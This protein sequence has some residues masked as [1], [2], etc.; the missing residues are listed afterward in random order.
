MTGL[1]R[2][3]RRFEVY[4]EP[5][6]GWYRA[7][8]WIV[9]GEE[10]VTSIVKAFSR[11]RPRHEIGMFGSAINFVYFQLSAGFV[12][13]GLVT[14]Q[15]FK[16]L[17]GGRFIAIGFVQKS[18]HLIERSVFE[19]ELDDV[20]YRGQLIRHGCV[21]PFLES[22]GYSCSFDQS[23]SPSAIFHCAIF[24]QEGRIPELQH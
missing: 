4:D 15:T 7:G 23:N 16:R 3:D 21:P 10:L 6:V 8:C 5:L 12:R 11:V 17:V 2:S 24:I 19:L 20:L 14:C 22:P 18:Y 13:I 9:C 1:I